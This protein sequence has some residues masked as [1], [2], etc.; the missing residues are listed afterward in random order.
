MFNNILLI[1]INKILYM[2]YI[3]YINKKGCVLNNSVYKYIYIL[4]RY[5][6]I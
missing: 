6:C 1:Y 3:N 5:V 4:Y 2:Y